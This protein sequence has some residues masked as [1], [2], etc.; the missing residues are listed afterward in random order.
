MTVSRGKSVRTDL[1]KELD[2]GGPIIER[3]ARDQD[4]E[5]QPNRVNQHMAF[6]PVD[7]LAS[8]YPRSAPPTS[9]VLTD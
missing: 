7:F 9:V 5:Q 6:A 2:G 3:R 8:S 4:D 1:G